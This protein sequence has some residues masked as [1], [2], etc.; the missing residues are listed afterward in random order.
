MPLLEMKQVSRHFG[1]Q[2]V[3]RCVNL[4]LGAGE[5]VVLV[6]PSGSG[7][8]VLLRLI[9]G[10]LEPD[11]GAILFRG[12][13]LSNWLARD[14]GAE[15][16]GQ[17]GVVFQGDALL[18]DLDV[19][20]NLRLADSVASSEDLEKIL[21]EVG[22]D[23][24]D[25]LP[26]LPSQLSGGMRKRVA[27]ARAL[28]RKPRLLL[29]D[30]PTAGLDLLSGQRI[31]EM[32]AKVTGIEGRTS[33]TVTHDPAVAA[34]VG[35]RV[36]RLD[37]STHRLEEAGGEVK[38]AEAM[39]RLLESS[40]SPLT[41]DVHE[42]QGDEDSSIL[43]SLGGMIGGFF[44]SLGEGLLLLRQTLRPPLLRDLR[45]R[46]WGFG[47]GAVPLIAIVSF[48]AGMMLAFQ[49]QLAI[50]P[51]G[52]S[53]A[54]PEIILT[55]IFRG[56]C[57]LLA[58]LLLAGKIGSSF[59]AEVAHMNLSDQLSALRTLGTLPE[60][61]LLP[62]AF[63]AALILFPAMI[64]LSEFCALAGGAALL[65]VPNFAPSITATFYRNECLRLIT[66]TDIATTLVT[67]LSFALLVITSAYLFASQPP[68]SRLLGSAITNTLVATAIGMILINFLV[69]AICYI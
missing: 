59:A 40:H 15:F 69:N 30:E 33:L 19:R 53:N 64:F 34:A 52:Y 55:S 65:L 57:P 38:D 22:L 25:V 26:K 67:A 60:R 62:A 16:Y 54:L 9:L 23:A 29:V 68:R 37:V 2:E 43:H 14:D 12:E 39:S 42:Q 50:E 48:V 5:S 56:L 21:A 49:A 61:V 24:L 44:F 45:R 17:I 32:L 8:S 20:E 4:A 36:F 28:L 63:S 1:P 51:Y 18:D 66:A 13:P 3:L 27:F 58:G 47:P 11:D 41:R 46:L 6:G 7:K 10:F 35:R 31:V